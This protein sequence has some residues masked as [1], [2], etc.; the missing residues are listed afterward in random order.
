M[1]V[2]SG[3]HLLRRL[4]GPERTLA[5]PSLQTSAVPWA[6]CCGMPSNSWPGSS[7]PVES[8]STSENDDSLM[9]SLGMDHSDQIGTQTQEVAVVQIF[10]VNLQHLMLVVSQLMV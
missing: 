8:R 9:N 1:S 4:P 3:N 6:I 5:P 2:P 10:L 7:A